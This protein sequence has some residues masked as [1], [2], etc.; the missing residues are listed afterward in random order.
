MDQEAEEIARCLLQKM[1]NTS[2]F[3][4]RAANRSLGAMVENVTPARSLVALTSAGI[5]HRNPL[6]RKCTAEHLSTVLEQIGA[7]KLLSGTRDNTEMLVHNLVRL[8]QDS[9]QD[10]RAGV[11][12]RQVEKLGVSQAAGDT[13]VS[14]SPVCGRSM[15]REAQTDILGVCS[16]QK[17]LPH[18]L[19]SNGPRLAGLR[20]SMRGGLQVA[21]KLREL[22]RLLEAKEY[23]SRMEGVGRLLELC[24]ATPELITANLV[25]VFDAFTPR[26]QDSNKKVNQW[27]LESLAK[28]IPLLKE[29]LHPMLLSIIVAVADNLNSKNS[30]IY[31]AAVTAL[32]A[33]IENLDN[34]CL[35]QTFAGRV[36][37]LSGRAV[38]DVTE[39]A[40]VYPQKPQAV[41]R[42]VLPV[43]WC[44]LSNMTRNSVLPGHGGNVRTVAHRL[45]RSLQ[46]QM[47]SR[48]QDLAA[49]QPQPVLETLQ[50]L[51]D[52]ATL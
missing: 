24:K 27:A 38:L 51:L 40:S 35:L 50:G 33:M 11:L 22:T 48:L 7:E 31:A 46:E 15:G 34:L 25:Q 23:Q 26:L 29:S 1:G 47:G 19:S 5:Y 13:L 43:L 30:G 39:L 20:S 4:Q 2:E 10:T 28:M 49:G 52:T 17:S 8:A 9:N 18:R 14:V 3:I 37:F 21:E 45:S 12:K 6:V 16:G 41:E 36:R 42:H 32:D 44:F